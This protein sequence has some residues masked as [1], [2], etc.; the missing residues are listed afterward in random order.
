MKDVTRH[1]IIALV[2]VLMLAGARGFAQDKLFILVRHAEKSASGTTMDMASGDPNLSDEGRTRAERFARIVKKYRPQEIYATD[3]KRTKQTAEPTAKIRGKEIQ[4]YDPAKQ[5]DLVT[6][7]MA[8]RCKRYLIVGHSNTTPALA[9]L[10]AK[11][12]VFKQLP[13]AEYGVYWVIR[14]KK[15]VVKRV[16]V[17]PF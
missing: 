4:T 1:L 15:G 8:A 14:I 16:E 17:Y 2:L 3:Y 12:D 6:K 13:D 7:M 11:K 5:A 9:N 10:I